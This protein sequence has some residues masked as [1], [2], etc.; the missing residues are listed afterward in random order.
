MREF[1]VIVVGGGPAG[2]VAAGR[3]ADAG[4]EVC[5]V[6]RELVGGECSFWACMPSKA[7]LR[8]AELLAEVARVP[9]A[10]EAV[11]AGVDVQATLDRRDEVVHDF[12]D[13]GQLPWLED[14]GIAL[15]RAHGRVTG[16]KVVTAGD[17]ELR[18][19][20]GVILATGS[21]A[22]LPPIPGLAEARP[23]TNREAAAARTVPP[24][25]LVLGGGVVGVEMAQAFASLGSAVTVVEPGP[26]VL[27]RE[28]PFASEQVTAG[29]QA[30]GVVVHCSTS[31]VR[32]H[33]GPDGGPVTVETDGAG[34]FE[35]DELLAATGRAARVADLGLEALGLEADGPV[36]VDDRL[37]VAGHDWLHVVG[38]L[39][40]RQLLTHMGKYQARVAA[41]VLCG[42]DAR[43]RPITDPPPRVVFTDPQV[44]AVGHT[45]ASAREAGIEVRVADVST[46]GNAGASF[47]GKDTPGTCRL[48]VDAARDVVVGATFT[49]AD[50]QEMLHAATIAVTAQVTLED[51]WHSIPAFP[52]RNEVWLKLSEALEA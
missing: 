27:A 25:L 45:E 49:G 9:G 33:R 24:R 41:D 30:L 26:R 8:P 52:T 28:E 10:R 13:S 36:E 47:K 22:A 19:R 46:S 7:L 3:L 37:R 31:A 4:L 12:D 44:A 6:E 34:T 43:V 17:E 2:E 29:L 18:A 14:R 50:V 40:G 21:A 39:N 11:A 35:A 20:R 42:R 51:L 16:E 5:L 32:V 48:V 1:D 38:D 15:V 23:W